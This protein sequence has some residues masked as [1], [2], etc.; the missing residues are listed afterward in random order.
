MF[1]IAVFVVLAIA[2]RVSGES[3]ATLS[4]SG[5]NWPIPDPAVA[6]DARWDGWC[7]RTFPASIGA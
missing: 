2:R 4:A 3:C 1:R 7:I 6:S 5:C